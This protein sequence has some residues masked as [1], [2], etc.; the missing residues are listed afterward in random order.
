MAKQS[1]RLHRLEVENW[2]SY[3]GRQVIGPFSDF[4][5]VIGPNGAGKSN[6]MDAVSFAV[7][8]QSKDLRG[9]QLKDLIYRADGDSDAEERRASVTLVYERDGRETKFQRCISSQGTGEYRIDSKLVS[10]DTYASRLQD[11]GVLASAHTGFLVF[12]GYVSELANKSPSELTALFEK[13]SGSEELKA[14][15]ERLA[16]EKKAAEDDQQYNFNKKRALGQERNNMKKQKEEAEKYSGLLGKVDELKQR[17]FLLRLFGIE[18][19]VTSLHAELTGQREEL[20]TATARQSAVEEAVKANEKEKSSIARERGEAERK[21]AQLQKQIGG[22]EPTLIRLREEITHIEKKKAVEAKALKK[23]EEKRE[24]AEEASAKLDTELSNIAETIDRL[25]SKHA[26]S[27]EDLAMGK[28]KR[29]EYKRL[30]T[31]AGAN[32]AAFK[33][34]LQAARRE[35]NTEEHLLVQLQNKAN[36]V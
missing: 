17:L 13:I 9:R 1:G 12:Q 19:E 2:K 3:G 29:S 20:E 15:D 31:L 4:T 14:E 23:A 7:G 27:Q 25:Q 6:L 24:R 26:G 11:L 18:V 22:K 5:A 35:L 21:A 30:K 36:E 10:Y 32:T 33:E 34:R 28:E 16:K 8:L